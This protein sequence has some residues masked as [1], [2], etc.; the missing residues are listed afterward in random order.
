VE[1]YPFLLS[2]L[3]QPNRRY[4]VI[5]NLPVRIYKFSAVY[6]AILGGHCSPMDYLRI[7]DCADGVVVCFVCQENNGLVESD[8]MPIACISFPRCG[9]V[10]CFVPYPCIFSMPSRACAGISVKFGCNNSMIGFDC[11]RMVSHYAWVW[12]G[13]R[14]CVKNI[15]P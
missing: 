3:L 11:A 4:P 6:P 13:W 1:S 14:T 9:C 2:F 7:G 12:I 10:P 5:I 8:V 15:F